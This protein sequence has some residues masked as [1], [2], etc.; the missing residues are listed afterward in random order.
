MEEVNHHLNRPL[1]R[2]DPFKLIRGL[3]C[4]E[5]CML[6]SLKQKI[7]DTQPIPEKLMVFL[8][9]QFQSIRILAELEKEVNKSQ[10]KYCEEKVKYHG[11]K[12][13]SER[14]DNFT[15]FQFFDLKFCTTVK[16][17]IYSQ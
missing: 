1:Y 10:R 2:G 3:K 7:D 8:K 5:K 9:I 6:A 11:E 14:Q 17:N 15:F 16:K 4:N 12:S 13:K